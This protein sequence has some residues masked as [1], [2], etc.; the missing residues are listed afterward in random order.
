MYYLDQWYNLH[1]IGLGG[2][3]RDACLPKNIK[4]ETRRKQRG[5]GIAAVNHF[6]WWLP[7]CRQ[8]KTHW[9]WYAL[10]IIG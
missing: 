1:T 4:K 3:E 10:H 6:T 2:S 9:S 7:G 5:T 8:V